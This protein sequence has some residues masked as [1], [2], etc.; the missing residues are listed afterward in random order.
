MAHDLPLA[1]KQAEKPR[2]LAKLQS[3]AA[4]DRFSKE[5]IALLTSGNKTQCDQATRPD[6]TTAHESVVVPHLKIFTGKI[7]ECGD[8]RGTIL[9][10]TE[11]KNRGVC[12]VLT[13]CERD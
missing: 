7:G 11:R 8:L 2:E 10:Q 6:Q 9:G 12:R 1:E 13:P 3:D 5:L 4:R